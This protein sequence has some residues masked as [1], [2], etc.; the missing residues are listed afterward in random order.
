[1]KHHNLSKK[2]SLTFLFLILLLPS[3]AQN[4]KTLV[5]DNFFLN[6]YEDNQ[7]NGVVLVAENGEVIYHR[8][9]GW[10]NFEQQ[11]TLTTQTPFRLASVSKQF[12]AMAIMILAEKGLLSYDDEIKMYLPE[13]PYE[14]VTIR[15]LLHHNSGIP[16]YFGLEYSIKKMFPDKLITNDDMIAYFG[17]EKPKLQFKTGKKASYSNTGYVFLASIVERISGKKFPKFLQE[18][19]FNP[20]DMCH[21]FV[22]DTKNT[23]YDLKEEITF[24]LDT[25]VNTEKT[26]V[27]REKAETIKTFTKIPRRRAFG[28]EIGTS[29]KWIPRDY[30]AF[31]GVYGEKSI[32]ASTEDLAKWDKAL[33]TEKLVSKE[34][35]KE[36]MTHNGI[37]MRNFAFGYGWKIY[38]KR[39]D[40]V[41]H[42]GLYRGYRTFIQRDL[43]TRNT[44]IILT[45]RRLGGKMYPIFET[46]EL[47]L[48]GEK[49]KMPK[50]T[51]QEKQALDIFEKMYK[52]DYQKLN[53]GA[54]TTLKQK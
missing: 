1:M 53:F 48:A 8:A 25:V 40:V 39:K 21:T 26:I 46:V 51:S 43:K 23:E 14:G 52:I 50:K 34:T 42:H 13:L 3:Y 49:Y 12:T 11:D 41:F 37:G 16:D 6:L 30:D 29:G 47:I 45:N 24:K 9:L 10:S 20:L 28:Y 36:A 31:D 44:I 33:Y 2:N 54:S 22:Y 38:D 35:L 15:N 5:L 19:I 4:N 27:L 18:N 7:F 32:C 17:K